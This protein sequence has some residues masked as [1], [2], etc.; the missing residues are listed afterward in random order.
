MKTTP[1]QI[2]QAREELQRTEHRR[3]RLLQ[4]LQPEEHDYVEATL[5]EIGDGIRNPRAA[6]GAGERTASF[7]NQRESARRSP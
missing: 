6:R 7:T 1:E 4:R 2:R 3:D 5:R